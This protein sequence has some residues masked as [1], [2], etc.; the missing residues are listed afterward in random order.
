MVASTLELD[1]NRCVSGRGRSLTAERQNHFPDK[2]EAHS[3]VFLGFDP[4]KLYNTG[5]RRKLEVSL[6]KLRCDICIKCINCTK[7]VIVM[8]A[9]TI[10]IPWQA[11]YQSWT[12]TRPP[13]IKEIPDVFCRSLIKQRK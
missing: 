10:E 8:V 7:W 12:K 3:S 13:T 4:E 1:M 2:G 11:W 6:Q 5:I 9:V